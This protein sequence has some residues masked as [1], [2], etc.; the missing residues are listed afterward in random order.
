MR[1][2]HLILLA[3]CAVLSCGSTC[4]KTPPPPTHVPSEPAL[5]SATAARLDEI[6]AHAEA[7]EVA[8]QHIVDPNVKAAVLGPLSVIRRLAPGPYPDETRAAALALVNKA[9]EGKLTEAHAGWAVARNEADKKAARIRELEAAVEREK[10]AAAAEIER[11]LDDARQKAE[12][13]QRLIYGLIFFG[14]A[15]V[16]AIAGFAVS[17]LAATVPIFGPNIARMCF[18]AAIVLGVMGLLMRIVDRLM[19]NHPLIFWGGLSF[20]ILAAVAACVFLI[21]NRHHAK[22]AP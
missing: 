9:L 3:A 14:G 16:C 17:S 8:A 13:K 15:A 7:A 4:Q 21:A 18:G 11:R 10:I 19:D 2:P 22:A 6:G 12:A 5:G 1:A 20:V